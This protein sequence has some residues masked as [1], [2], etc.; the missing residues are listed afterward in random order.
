M[1]GGLRE[2]RAHEGRGAG[3]ACPGER[4]GDLLAAAARGGAQRVLVQQMR[5]HHVHDDPAHRQLGRLELGDAVGG[6]L[7][8]HLLQEGHQMDRGLGGLQHPHHGLGLIVYRAYPGQPR[9]LVV[10]VEEAGD[11]AGRRGVHD[12]VVVDEPVLLVL[13]A[14]R[15]AGLAG[16]QDVPDAGRDRGGEVDRAELLERPARAAELVEHLEVVE[17]GALGVD[18]EGVHLPAARCDGDLAL[19]VGEGFRLEELGDALS[20]LDLDEEGAPALGREGEREGGG[21]RGLTG[22]ALAADD[23]EPAHVFEPNQ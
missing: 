22:T 15:L 10:H 16:Q 5:A 2:Q 8:R 17:E 4:F 19:L 7:D 23:L 6:L 21:D 14:H 11:A 13:A 12:H 9:H 18:R 3:H 20:A 1:L